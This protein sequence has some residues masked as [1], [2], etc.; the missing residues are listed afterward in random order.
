MNELASQLFKT[1]F[2]SK[3]YFL[4][5]KL[6]L[7]KVISKT[8]NFRGN[9][10]D[11]GEVLMIKCPKL[12]HRWHSPDISNTQNFKCCEFCA[13][14][15][16]C[17][18]WSPELDIWFRMTLLGL[19]W[20]EIRI[21]LWFHLKIYFFDG[22]WCSVLSNPH[23]IMSA[24]PLRSSVLARFGHVQTPRWLKKHQ[25]I[26]FLDKIIKNPDFGLHHT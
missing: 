17:A 9:L 10:I 14:F 15:F 3:K 18:Y 24:N 21:F 12:R 8:E 13:I 20:P 1:F 23:H 19:M 6:E 4:R 25:K 2:R 5:K 26:F 22:F 16:G 7:G 11:F